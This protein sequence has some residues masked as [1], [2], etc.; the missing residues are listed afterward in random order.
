VLL[1][2]SFLALRSVCGQV[3]Y[4]IP[5]EMPKG[6]VVGNMVRDFGLDVKRLKSGKARVFTRDNDGFIELNK[7]RGVLLIKD[8]IDREALCGQ[9][10][11]C[12]LHFQIILE[13]P[14]EFYSVT[15]E[16]TDVNDNPPSF[17]KN[18]VKFKI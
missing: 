12:A 15:V 11:P 4:S 16:I 2:F 18:D 13:N 7:E 17:E 5:E 10:T 8:R 3:S 1:L 6:S 14:M 9:A